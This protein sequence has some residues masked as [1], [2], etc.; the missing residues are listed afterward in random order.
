[1]LDALKDELLSQV[2]AAGD[3]AALEEV[4]VTA[5]GKK[6]RITGF[7]KEL[8]GL[9]PD[10]RRERGQQLN[11]LK[12]EIAA[13]IDGR[14]ADLARAH[15]EARL[16]AERIDVTLPIRPQTEGRIHPIS[17][18][19]DEMVAIFAEMGFSVAEGPDVED[20]FHNFT[21]LNFPPGHPARDMHDTFYLPDAGDK[22]MLLRTHTSPVQVRTM[23]NKK[24]PIRIIAPGRTYRSDYDM[25]HTPMFHQ[26]EGLVIDEA[27]HMGHLKGCLIEFCRAFFDVD[28]LPL[29]FRPSFFPFTEPS[30]EVDIGC[31][32]KGGELKLGN[33]GDWLEI[34]GCGMVHPNVLEACGIDSTK[35][36]GFAFGMGIERVA[37]LKYGIPDLRT[38]FEADLRWLKH[39]G[40]VPLDVPSMAQGLTR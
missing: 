3:L 31:S 28:D 21:A 11:A 1:M 33:Y 10:E 6:G 9:S 4:R 7:M 36:Q 18:T 19:I 5:L 22:K 38:F 13:A 20:D 27:T 40:F 23:L 30:A 25:T 29:R 2:N 32:R 24:P 35:Y 26:I 8:G 14:K 37:M 15:L 39:Y 16:Q 12:D 17:Q 34:L